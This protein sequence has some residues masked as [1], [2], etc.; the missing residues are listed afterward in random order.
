MEKAVKIISK[1]RAVYRQ[2][3]K[4][5]IPAVIALGLIVGT[6]APVYV[7]VVSILT[8]LG[9]YAVPNAAE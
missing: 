7:D 6:H 3:R 1:A 5:A 2:C 9:V 4:A 8:A